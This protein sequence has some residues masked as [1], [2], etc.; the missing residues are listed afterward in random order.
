MHLVCM[1][2]YL[3][4]WGPW[5]WLPLGVLALGATERTLQMGQQWCVTQTSF[6]FQAVANLLVFGQAALAVVSQ[7][8]LDEGSQTA[9]LA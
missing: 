8:N 2:T 3:A 6:Q 9:E 4:A 5:Y 1:Q 7:C